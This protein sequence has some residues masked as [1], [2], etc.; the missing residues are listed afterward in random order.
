MKP[1]SLSLLLLV[2]GFLPALKASADEPLVDDAFER[3]ELG[4]GWSVN[5]GEWKIVDAHRMRA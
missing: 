5:K 2:L 4:E 3:T 1:K